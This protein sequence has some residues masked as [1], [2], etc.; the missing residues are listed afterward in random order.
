MANLVLMFLYTIS[1]IGF[2]VQMFYVTQELMAPSFSDME[3][4]REKLGLN[5]FLTSPIQNTHF[6]PITPKLG[7]HT[8]KNCHEM[9]NLNLLFRKH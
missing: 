1:A 5:Q 9:N 7:G 2:M 4:K 3:L 8:Y 6:H